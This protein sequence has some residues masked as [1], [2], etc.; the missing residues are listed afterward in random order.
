ML[1]TPTAI[2]PTISGSLRS[3]DDPDDCIFEY[4]ACSSATAENKMPASF[5]VYGLVHPARDQGNRQTCA[6]FTGAAIKEIQE[7][8]DCGFIERMSPEFIYY[9]RDN[10]PKDGMYGRDVFRILQNIGSVPEDMYPYINDDGEAQKYPA[11]PP[12]EELYNIAA[13]Y[14]IANFARVL[15]AEG[16]RRA[17]VDVGPCYLLLPLYSNRP[18]F[19]RAEPGEHPVCGHA[20]TVIGYAEDYFILRNSWGHDWNGNGHIDFP[21]ADWHCVWECWLPTDEK[22]ATTPR[23]MIAGG[24]SGDGDGAKSSDPI[25]IKPGKN[26]SGGGCAMM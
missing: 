6:A 23:V 15:S 3:P 5:D 13:K 10:K 14:R 4:L 17:L 20:V 26:C 1:T 12:T 11:P 24:T 25:M 18:Y 8:A 21:A 16:L 19:W 9:H 22:T 2:G 7:Y